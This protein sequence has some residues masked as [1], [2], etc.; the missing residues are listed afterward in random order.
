MLRTARLILEPLTV[1]H[2]DLLFDGLSDPA[3]Y[4][5]I[6]PEP[7]RSLEEKRAHFARILR[8]PR[9]DPDELWRNWAVKITATGR[10]AGM[11]ETSLF[12][13]D[14]AHL[15]YF[16]FASVQRQGFAKEACE[17]VLEHLAAAYSV[18]TVVA[19]MDTRNAASWRLVEAL[20]FTRVMEKRDADFFKGAASHEYH[21]RL[22][23]TALAE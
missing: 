14:R 17:A 21:Y 23:L 6:P 4:E 2:A 11:I 19:E 18:K 13:G 8:G 16:I 10:Y 9:D 5:F 22:D 12:P 1:D 20:G 15:A 7:P 3:L